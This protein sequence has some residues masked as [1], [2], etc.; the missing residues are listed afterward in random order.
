MIDVQIKI[1]DGTILTDPLVIQ[2]LAA[3]GLEIIRSD[4]IGLVSEDSPVGVYGALQGG[5]ME[6]TMEIS[7]TA[8]TASVVNAQPYAHYLLYGSGPARRNPGGFLVKW[9]DKKLPVATQYRI[10]RMAGMSETSARN[11]LKR[12]S[13]QFQTNSLTVA[14]AFIIGRARIKRGSKGSDFVTPI[15][16]E[17]MEFWR[18][19]FADVVTSGRAA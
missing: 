3:K 15:I 8:A 17:H 16:E 4:F 9:V 7:S 6:S 12:S 14:V 19:V 2:H 18:D 10:A 11:A 13:V 1:D 5:W